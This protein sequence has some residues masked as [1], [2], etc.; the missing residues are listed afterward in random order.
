MA[1]ALGVEARCRRRT[2]FR[3]EFSPLVVAGALDGLV[4][5]ARHGRLLA[6]ERPERW[7]PFSVW[8]TRSWR[9]ASVDAAVVAANHNRPGQLQISG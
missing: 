2:L 7:P 8:K 6:R 9:S 3:R 4:A 1:K 5:P